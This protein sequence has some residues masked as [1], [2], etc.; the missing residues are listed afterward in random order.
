MAAPP[1]AT[2][3]PRPFTAD[4][5]WRMVDAGIIRPDERVELLDGEL[6][7][8][9]PSSPAHAGTV[10]RLNAALSHIYLPEREVRVQ[11]VLPSG[12]R[13]LPEPDLV[14]LP[15]DLDVQRR[16]PRAEETLLAIE[17]AV[18][19]MPV[20]RR[21]ARIYAAAGVPVYWIVDVD[22]RAVHVLQDPSPDGYLTRHTL[23]GDARLP[24]PGAEA[25]LTVREVLPPL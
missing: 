23:S 8:V 1:P 2:M 16:H 25:H 3:H 4:E 11:S 22:G 13:S 10:Q 9:S 19:S 24:L 6:V 20:D 5:V 14:I 17:V 21:K 12:E 18:T 15:A 7:V